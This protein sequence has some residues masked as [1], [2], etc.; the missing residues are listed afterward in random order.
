MSIVMAKR[1][2]G[3]TSPVV[4]QIDK[5]FLVCSICLDH[6]HN[7]KVLPCLHTFCESCLQ[8]YIPAESLT[9]SCPVCRQTSILPEKGVCALQNNFFITNLMEVLQREPECSRPEACSVLESVSAAAAGK[10]LCC[11]NHEGKVM[12]FYCESCET[13]MCLDCTEGEHGDHM[14][15]PLRDVVEQHKAAL[16]TQLDAIHSR[17]PQLTAAIELVSEISRQLNERKTEAVAEIN[18]TFEELER[19]LH[20]RKT[21]LITDLENICSSKQKVL[22]TQLSSLLQGKEHIQSSCSFTE[23]ALSHGNAT[24]VL[25]VQKQMSERVTALAR[26]D[27]P[28]KPHQNAHLD[29]QVETEGL[30]RSIQN[31]GVLLTTSAVAHTS[32]ATGEGLRHAATGQHKTITVTTKDKDGELVRTGNAVLKAEILSA[33]GNR[34]AETEITDNKNGTYEVGYT[35]RSEGEYSFSLLLYGQPIRGSPFRLRAVKPSDVPQSPDD[36]KRRVKSPSGTGGHIRQKAV[37]RPSS[38]Y[39]TTKKKENPIEDELIYR[40]G[41]R[42]REK[43]EFTNL[44]GISASSNGRV[45]VADS[46]NQCIQVFSNDGQFKMRFGVRG[47]SPGQLQ[48]PTGVTVDMNGDIVV[49]DYDNRWVSIFSSDGKFKNK[50]GAGRLMGPKGVAVDK[51]GHIITVDNKACCVFIFQSNGKLVTKFGGRGT[52]DRQFAEKLGPNFNKSGS[53]FSPHFVAVNNKNEIIVTDFHNHSVKVYSADGEFLFKFGSHGEGNGQ[54]NAPTGVAVDTNGNIIVA[55][56][57]NSRIQVFDSTGSFLSYINT[58]ADPLYGPQGLALTSDGH[59]AVAD[60]GNH[61]FKVYRY[62]Q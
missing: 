17:L 13:A 48:R 58:S 20:H 6:Y 10:P 27:F 31:L 1:D 42:G 55:D 30:R 38:M 45:V 37:R 7:P 50:I 3:S 24:E 57:G 29:C 62:L 12:E 46:N 19:L 4:R 47:R 53:V 33:D 11:P 59:V 56:W 39:S 60:S 21:A 28:E 51:N 2:T 9:L 54:F 18:S 36:V 15:V 40:V 16:K 22:H 8:N 44:Q 23:Q 49:A 43:G 34:A 41:S 32:V 61:C 5:Q 35:L 25:L 52:S 26:H 14:T